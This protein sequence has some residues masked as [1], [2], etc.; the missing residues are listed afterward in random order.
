MHHIGKK[1]TSEWKEKVHQTGKKECSR[2]GRKSASDWTSNHLKG[3]KLEKESL[4]ILI[5]N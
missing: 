1:N 4:E 3:R 2:Q 5:E